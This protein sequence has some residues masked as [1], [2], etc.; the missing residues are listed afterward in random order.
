MPQPFM[1]KVVARII[2]RYMI[3]IVY[4]PNLQGESYGQPQNNQSIGYIDYSVRL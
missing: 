4:A 1:V 2:A 3:F